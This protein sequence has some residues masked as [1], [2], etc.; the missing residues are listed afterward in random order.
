MFAMQAYPNFLPR[1]ATRSKNSAWKDFY[2]I[3]L[4]LSFF[5]SQKTFIFFPP[6]TFLNIS[7]I[8][9]SFHTSR[10]AD[11]GTFCSSAGL[12]LSLN[13]PNSNICE[14]RLYFEF[15]ATNRMSGK[16][17]WA[18]IFGPKVGKVGYFL[19]FFQFFKYNF[20]NIYFRR[21]FLST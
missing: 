6:A 2:I 1:G 11:K 10:L 18:E 12:G 19:H 5:I 15:T 7:L 14:T 8:L 3:L 21:K 20:R 17:L 4:Y 13:I 16:T 9:K